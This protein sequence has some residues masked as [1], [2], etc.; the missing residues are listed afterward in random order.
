VLDGP[1]SRP[2]TKGPLRVHP[3]NPRYFADSSG[4]ALLLAG[5]H[6]WAT[7]QEAGP[8]D[9]PEPFDWPGWL[10]FMV[11]HDHNFMRLW[12]WENAKWGSWWDGDYYFSPVAFARTGPG[13]ARDGKPKFDL[14]QFD[15][16]WFSR[17]R[18]RVIDLRDRGIYTAVMLFNGWSGGDKPYT[19]PGPNPWFGH[20]FQKDNNVNGIDGSSPDGEGR[21]WVHTLRNPDVVRLQEAYVRRV[22]DTV[23]DLDNV[24]FEIGN[25]HEGTPANN[26]W[27][28]HMVNVVHEYEESRP[29]QHPVL[30]TAPWPNPDNDLLFASAAEAVSP[31]HWTGRH[32]DHWPYDPPARYLGKVVIAD[33]DHLWGVGG[34][35][36]WVWRTFTRGHNVLYMDPYGYLHMDPINPDG[37]E[38]A[39]K[40]MGRCLALSRLVDLAEMIPQPDLTSSG[41]ALAAEGREYIV[42]HPYG[43][44]LLVDLVGMDGPVKIE[45]YH[46][47]DDRVDR[48]PDLAGGGVVPLRPPDAQPWAIHLAPAER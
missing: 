28:Y 45:W 5:S 39:R 17:L 6:T 46:P 8:V 11:E 2:A 24:M 33:T 29:L 18:R 13:L 7:L 40:A 34:H 23:G 16:E 31:M 30:M 21:E 36:D 26:A 27:Q 14:A 38:G 19:P 42:Y 12:T 35:A 15:E 4:R 3:H 48:G 9:P 20:P 25:E 10:K 47:V 44:R 43:D 37:D 32:F 41:F 22:V 1:S